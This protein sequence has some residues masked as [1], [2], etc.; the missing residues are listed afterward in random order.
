VLDKSILQK[1][2]LRLLDKVCYFPVYLPST[3]I[4]NEC[5]YFCKIFLLIVSVSYW[6]LD[7]HGKSKPLTVTLVPFD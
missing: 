4:F 6:K 3:F 2:A 7:I 1:F 5:R